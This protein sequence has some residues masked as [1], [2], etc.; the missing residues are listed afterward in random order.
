[1]REPKNNDGQ[2]PGGKGR[3]ELIVSQYFPSS[4]IRNADAN[5]S[6]GGGSSSS[7]KNSSKSSSTIC[8]AEDR[9]KPNDIIHQDD[10]HSDTGGKSNGAGADRGGG[11][12]GGGGPGRGGG[13]GGGSDRQHVPCPTSS[14]SAVHVQEEA[15]EDLD[16]ALPVMETAPRQSTTATTGD[17]NGECG[18]VNYDGGGSGSSGGGDGGDYSGAEGRASK[19]RM[20]TPT[21]FV[22]DSSNTNIPHL[23]APDAHRRDASGHEPD[24]AQ[25]SDPKAPVPLAALT[26]CS[27]KSKPS[28]SAAPATAAAAV[29]NATTSR[30]GKA[31]SASISGSSPALPVG[32]QL[33]SREKVSNFTKHDKHG[34]TTACP[35]PTAA[36][37]AAETTPTKGTRRNGS[38]S[39]EAAAP[40]SGGVGREE[41]RLNRQREA[42]AMLR[43]KDERLAAKRA[44][45]YAAQA[46]AVG[47][48]LKAVSAQHR[49]GAGPAGASD[50]AGPAVASE[51]ALAFEGTSK[52]QQEPHA[53]HAVD[54]DAKGC[55]AAKHAEEAALPNTARSAAPATALATAP[56]AAAAAVPFTS[57]G[58]LSPADW[59]N[60]S[61]S[62]IPPADSQANQPAA[63]D[64]HDTHAPTSPAGAMQ[65]GFLADKKRS[66][67][68]ATIFDDDDDDDSAAALEKGY[69]EGDEKYA[70]DI[71]DCPAGDASISTVGVASPP[72]HK[73]SHVASALGGGTRVEIAPDD[74]FSG[75]I[76]PVLGDAQQRGGPLRMEVQ[77][78]VHGGSW[79]ER[80]DRDGE[81]GIGSTESA[82]STVRLARDPSRCLTTSCDSDPQ[83][84]RTSVYA[85][86]G[87]AVAATAEAR[88]AVGNKSVPIFLDSETTPAPAVARTGVD[89]LSNT[90]LDTTISNGSSASHGSGYCIGSAV[91]TEL[92]ETHVTL[93]SVISPGLPN[94]SDQLGDSGYAH[95]HDVDS[96]NGAVDD[97]EGAGG[98][99]A[100]EESIDHFESN[101]QSSSIHL[102]RDGKPKGTWGADQS[103]LPLLHGAPIASVDHHHSLQVEA[104]EG[105]PSQGASML[106]EGG[107]SSSNGHAAAAGISGL[108]A[109][110]AQERTHSTQ[111]AINSLLLLSTEKEPENNPAANNVRQHSRYHQD[112]YR[113]ASCSLRGSGAHEIPPISRSS[114]PATDLTQ[115]EDEEEKGGDVGGKRLG[116][117]IEPWDQVPDQDGHP[118]DRESRSKDEGGVKDQEGTERDQRETSRIIVTTIP[119][120][121]CFSATDTRGEFGSTAQAGSDSSVD[122]KAKRQ[123]LILSTTTSATNSS[124]HETVVSEQTR[125]SVNFS[126]A[127]IVPSTIVTASTATSAGVGAGAGVTPAGGVKT[128]KRKLLHEA[129]KDPYE[130]YHHPEGSAVSAVASTARTDQQCHQ[131][132]EPDDR[133]I[134]ATTNTSTTASSSK[135]I[136]YNS[137]AVASTRNDDSYRKSND[138]SFISNPNSPLG[139]FPTPVA[140]LHR[141]TEAL[142]HSTVRQSIASV[143]GT[144]QTINPPSYHPS[145]DTDDAIVDEDSDE[146]HSTRYYNYTTGTSARTGGS[147]A[148]SSHATG[149]CRGGGKAL[150]TPAMLHR[151]RLYQD[152]G[153][154]MASTHRPQESAHLSTSATTSLEHSLSLHPASMERI[155]T[156]SGASSKVQPILPLP[157][158]SGSSSS[159]SSSS[160]RIS[161]ST[162]VLSSGDFAK[163]ARLIRN[164]A[165]SSRSSVTAQSGISRGSNDDDDDDDI[166]FT[167]E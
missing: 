162:A 106:S 151:Q 20:R 112:F 102:A 86:D 160:T 77:H 135:I 116:G 28:V 36:T 159:S 71:T 54:Q 60:D 23:A 81:K 130:N 68:N 72:M 55:K 88:V 85:G 40:G 139:G 33:R 143:M 107:S 137:T 109:A 64:V 144:A 145:Q 157:F 21:A 129:F 150:P 65:N 156:T 10:S 149:S 51:A 57:M 39:M 132:Q 110:A 111:V 163:K 79:A 141:S 113:Q 148:I 58:G 83:N 18:F 70:A 19:A 5:G 6:S 98:E 138:I 13:G 161:S 121:N 128:K 26:S 104:G 17:S 8:K 24:D 136:K 48:T 30:S 89:V 32:R 34:R 38:T 101:H 52:E 29:T 25:P 37:A 74:S 4:N 153:D 67:Q 123:P 82:Y 117:Y 27:S 94:K 47:T 35:S 62:P 166:E 22:S 46:A 2:S 50:A 53:S 152:A 41:R 126:S 45:R 105:G 91:P 44:A 56:V 14:S 158:S 61:Q 73:T 142:S 42:E 84:R 31:P 164:S 125:K 66:R 140:P 165:L 114:N 7:R 154:L 131:Q 95:D 127:A 11:G 9:N 147:G 99:G 80:A 69:P 118:A 1:M 49:V 96:V 63:H 103:H 120:V 87:N 97:V 3:G 122:G 59:M 133:T 75:F 100:G 76:S 115:D 78:S 90:L 108:P 93:G 155:R 43:Q 16:P 134:M 146:D 15:T 119:S 167:Q 124:L 12:G 92:D